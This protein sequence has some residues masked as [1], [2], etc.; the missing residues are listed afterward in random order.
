MDTDQS[1]AIERAKR[2]LYGHTT[3]TLMIDSTPNDIEYIVDPRTGS[4]VL[5]AQEDM[6][7]GDDVVLVVPEDRFDSPLRLSLELSTEIDEEPCDRFIAYHLHQPRPIWICGRIHFAKLDSGSV[8]SDDELE[9]PNPLV[10]A[11]PGLC[12]KLNADRK[13][14][15]DVCLL[16]TRADIKEPVAVGVDPIG[17]DVRSRFGVVRVEFPG[18]V[19]NA[20]QAEDVIAALLGGVS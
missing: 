12:K 1:Q 8:V 7:N 4:L 16:L 2:L 11:L 14:L 6:L 9:V 15:H 5:T 10:D 13:A 18:V 3:G 17:F 20:M 19:E